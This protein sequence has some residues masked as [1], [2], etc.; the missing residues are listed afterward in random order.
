MV[1]G[2]LRVDPGSIRQIIIRVTVVRIT[3]HPVIRGNNSITAGGIMDHH[4]EAHLGHLEVNIR[5]RHHKVWAHL[6]LKVRGLNI[7]R[8]RGREAHL[9]RRDLNI[10]NRGCR[11]ATR[12]IVTMDL[13]ITPMGLQR[14]LQD[15]TLVCS[16]LHPIAVHLLGIHLVLI[17]IPGLQDHPMDIRQIV[18]L[19]K[20]ILI[21]SIL[22]TN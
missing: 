2:C 18:S 22:I 3:F 9:D 4:P 12:L 15:L 1:C 16:L 14:D 19:L 10:L 5:P 20:I 8:L 13:P 7:I 6:V 17:R 21:I 11:E